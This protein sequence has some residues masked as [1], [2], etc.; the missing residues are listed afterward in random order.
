M[1]SLQLLLSSNS[2][3]INICASLVAQTVK[4]QSTIGRPVFHPWVGKIPWKRKWQPTPVLLP[5]KSR[6]LRSLVGYSPWGHKESDTTEQLH[7]STTSS[8]FRNGSNSN[9]TVSHSGSQN[10]MEEFPIFYK[11]AKLFLLN[12]VSTNS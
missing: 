7:H 4:R 9:S 11:T 12:C 2:C 8:H 6:G 5:G 10:K 1:N 3:P